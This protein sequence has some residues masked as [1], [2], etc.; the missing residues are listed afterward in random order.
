MENVLKDK[1]PKAMIDWLISEYLLLD[2]FYKLKS[3]EEE[4]E[5]LGEE[6]TSDFNIWEYVVQLQVEHNI[7]VKKHNIERAFMNSDP[8][9]VIFFIVIS[10][11]DKYYKILY[12]DFGKERYELISIKEVIEIESIDYLE[13]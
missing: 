7:N 1:L 9:Y 3:K 4:V 11:D 12:K 13:K 8:P 6:I 2:N 10:F 5:Y